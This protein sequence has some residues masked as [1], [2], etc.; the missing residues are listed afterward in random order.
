M[1][2]CSNFNII[3]AYILCC[4]GCFLLLFADAGL[5]PPHPLFCKCNFVKL[6]YNLCFPIGSIEAKHRW[7]DLFLCFCDFCMCIFMHV[8]DCFV[9]WYVCLVCICLSPVC[10]FHVFVCT[11]VCLCLIFLC[12]FM[13]LGICAAGVHIAN[14]TAFVLCVCLSIWSA[15]GYLCLSAILYV[16]VCISFVC[17]CMCETA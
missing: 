8:C 12:T 17:I 10:L 6:I 14:H 4:C 15:L 16:V 7:S 9:C 3:S 1:L 5:S 13:C 11:H 2:E